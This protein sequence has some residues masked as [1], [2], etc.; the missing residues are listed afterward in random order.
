MTAAGSPGVDMGFVSLGNRIQR[1]ADNVV[2]N[3]HPT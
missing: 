2:I 1:I 3:G